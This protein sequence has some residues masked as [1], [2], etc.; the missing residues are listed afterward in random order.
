M[1]GQDVGCGCGGD[2]YLEDEGDSSVFRVVVEVF[3]KLK[4]LNCFFFEGLYII[5]LKIIQELLCSFLEYC[6]EILE[7]MCIWVWF[8]LQDRFS[9]LKGVLI[10]VKI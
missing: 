6:L 5:E 1:V 7:W 3:G 2:D 9:L 8:L 10:E 4:D